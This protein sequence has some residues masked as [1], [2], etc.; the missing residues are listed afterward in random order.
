[1]LMAC[2]SVG[3][4]S[5]E[6]LIAHHRDSGLTGSELALRGIQCPTIAG[7]GQAQPQLADRLVGGGGSAS[8]SIAKLRGGG[9]MAT[10]VAFFLVDSPCGST[11]HPV[12]MHTAQLPWVLILSVCLQ[13]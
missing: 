12:A 2:L 7:P 11:V 4:L 3:L 13:V 1:M 10:R 8:L 9:G 5:G 6:W